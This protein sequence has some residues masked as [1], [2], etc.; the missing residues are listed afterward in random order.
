MA[1][2]PSAYSRV[3]A[4]ESSPAVAE[5]RH[6]C[7]SAR[8]GTRPEEATRSGQHCR[9]CTTVFTWVRVRVRAR[10][11][12]RV[13]VMVGM[14]VRAR[15]SRPHHRRLAGLGPGARPRAAEQAS[16]EVGAG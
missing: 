4:A 10:A 5:V 3:Q 16:G 1:S 9:I 14:R 8:K 12:V 6:S 11:K 7:C 2:A 15:V 13:G